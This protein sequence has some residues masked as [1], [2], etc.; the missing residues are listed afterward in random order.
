M[1]IFVNIFHTSPWMHDF[2]IIFYFLMNFIFY[3][4]FNCATVQ[5]WINRKSSAPIRLFTP[6]SAYSRSKNLYDKSANCNGF[7]VNYYFI[8]YY[9][10]FVYQLCSQVLTVCILVICDVGIMALVL[11]QQKFI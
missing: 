1:I 6:A 11:V 9:Y 7:D 2:G 10:F 5:K 3:Y 8:L 4:S